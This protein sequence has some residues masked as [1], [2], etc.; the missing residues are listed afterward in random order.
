MTTDEF[1]TRYKLLKQIT[2][3]EG[4]SFTAQECASGRAVL[5]HFLAEN[6]SVPGSSVP[7]L[8]ARLE[9]RDRSKILEVLAVDQS[10]V[11]VTQF[12]EDF[13]GFDAWLQ[14]RL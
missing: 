5:V 13:E 1:D 11:V 6:E 2:T 3:G 7:T 8:I 9:P 10:T 14:G 12:L 4:R